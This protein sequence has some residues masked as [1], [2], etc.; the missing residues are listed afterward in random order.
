MLRKRLSQ[1]GPK[2]AQEVFCYSL[3]K[4]RK[5][6]PK[7]FHFSIHLQTAQHHLSLLTYYI[8]NKITKY[9]T[10]AVAYLRN[11]RGFT[12]PSLS[13]N[14]NSRVIIY[15]LHYLLLHHNYWKILS[16]ILNLIWSQHVHYTWGSLTTAHEGKINCWPLTCTILFHAKTPMTLFS[17][18]KN[19][20]GFKKYG[21][22]LTNIS[23]LL[24]T[25]WQRLRN[26]LDQ[27]QNQTIWYHT[28]QCIYWLIERKLTPSLEV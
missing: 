10:S 14:N 7:W 6:W 19:Y 5:P 13:T 2:K 17:S 18:L 23:T 4:C 25:T 8:K 1:K 27:F 9:Q 16:F 21:V 26:I 22:T 12:A 24:S 20:Q 15:S 11:L 28:Y 3:V